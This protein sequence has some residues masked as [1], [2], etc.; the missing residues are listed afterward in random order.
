VCVCC[1]RVAPQDPLKLIHGSSIPHALQMPTCVALLLALLLRRQLARGGM[2]GR[3]AFF[4]EAGVEGV[5]QV[6]VGPNLELEREE[7]GRGRGEE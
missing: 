5:P 4:R 1:G 6:G 2:A 3:Q 7:R